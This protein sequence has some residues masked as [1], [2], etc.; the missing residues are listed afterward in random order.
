MM[1]PTGLRELESSGARILP[2]PMDPKPMQKSVQARL[3]RIRR[4]MIVETVTRLTLLLIFYIFFCSLDGR[5]PLSLHLRIAAVLA[6][7]VLVPEVV[8][9]WTNYAEARRAVA[10]MWAIGEMEFKDLSSM[11]ETRKVLEQEAID[12]G[13]YTDVLREQIGDSLTESERQVVLVVEQMN[14]LIDRSNRQQEHIATLVQ[15]GRQLTETTREK[16]GANKELV[17]AIQTQLELQLTQLRENLQQIGHMSDEVCALTPL[18]KVITSIAQQT[19]LLALNAE[20][21]AARA[22]SMGRGFSVV[23]TEVRK[24]A[25]LSTKT[26]AD[27]SEKIR[28]TCKNAAVELGN[29][30]EALHRQEV[31]VAMSHFADD[32]DSMQED[33]SRN[34]ELLL[35]VITDVD[36]NYREM[37]SRLSD[38]LGHIQFQDIM[39]Q[40]MGHVQ[41]ALRDLGDHVQQLAVSSADTRWSGHLDRTFKDMLD[42]H[43]SQ[44]RMASQARTHFAVAGGEMT[45]RLDGPA[46]ELF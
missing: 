14:H 27:V 38:A 3:G 35:E 8:F 1:V 21:E 45:N 15:S 5:H 11:V 41:E 20:I 24:L 30:K 28:T 7:L 31:K 17:A 6:V 36:S 44:Y 33:F 37:T 10:D 4:R 46:I 18:I 42:A 39:R 12:C 43:L 2:V 13:V 34:G 25:V 22:G 23:A 32:L 40:R 29:A 26:A 16:V 9:R 19:G